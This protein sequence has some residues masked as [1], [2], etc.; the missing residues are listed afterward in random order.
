MKGAIADPWAKTNRINTSESTTIMGT[1]HHIFRFQKKDNISA[2]IP[3]RES[4]G[5]EFWLLMLGVGDRFSIISE[6]QLFTQ[7]T[8]EPELDGGFNFVMKASIWP[9][10]IR[11]STEHPRS[12]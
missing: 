3:R 7:G 4:N 6:S 2:R 11:G 8:I 1:S 12:C 10:G 9:N 5:D